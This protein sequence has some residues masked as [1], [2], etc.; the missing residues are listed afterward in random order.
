MIDLKIP[1]T[2]VTTLTFKVHSPKLSGLI[3]QENPFQKAVSYAVSLKY[4]SKD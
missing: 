3:F 4:G 1:F 2:V